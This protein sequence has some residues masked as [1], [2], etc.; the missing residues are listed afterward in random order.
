VISSAREKHGDAQAS[1]EFSALPARRLILRRQRRGR[2]FI[3]R[4]LLRS[5]V[6]CGN[7]QESRDKDTR[8]ENISPFPTG[9]LVHVVFPSLW[10]WL[11]LWVF[12]TWLSIHVRSISRHPAE[13]GWISPEMP[14]T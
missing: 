3:G 7:Y 13:R 1:A 10:F 12:N 4:W 11:N 2:R 14:E 6:L 9:C 5:R 8:H